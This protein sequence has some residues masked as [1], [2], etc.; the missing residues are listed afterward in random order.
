MPR[1]VSALAVV[2]SG[3]MSETI[4]MIFTKICLV[5]FFLV[6]MQASFYSCQ[7]WVVLNAVI[8][9][10]A[11]GIFRLNSRGSFAIPLK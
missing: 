6:V 11:W 9:E 10:L 4:M 2:A 8:V 1:H 5:R 7:I 3:T